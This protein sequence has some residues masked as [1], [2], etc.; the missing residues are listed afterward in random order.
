MCYRYGPLIRLWCMRFEAKHQELKKARTS[1]NICLTLSK[2]QQCLQAYNI[3]CNEN[4]VT[5]STSNSMGKLHTMVRGI[6]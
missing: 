2:F 4:F 3:Q 6:T 5:L 1:F